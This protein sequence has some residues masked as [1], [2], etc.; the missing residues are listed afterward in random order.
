MMLTDYRVRQREHLLRITRA[1]TA[2]LDLDALLRMILQAATEMLAGQAG[3]VA[4]RVDEGAESRY[5]AR[6]SIGIPANRVPLFAPLL[7]DVTVGDLEQLK[8][9]MRTIGPAVGLRQVVALP[10]VVQPRAVGVIYVFRAYGAGF[11]AD[12]EQVLQSFA[13]QAAI[14]VH[15]AQ[16]YQQLAQEKHRLD[17]LIEATADGILIMDSGHRIVR[18]NHAMGRLAGW[19]PAAT[20]GRLHDEVI[21]FAR[22]PSSTTLDDAEAHGWPL[23][24][25]QDAL[26]GS[27]ALYV[28]AD[29]RRPDGSTVSVGLNYS[30]LL[31][32]DGR[33]INLIA[34]ARDLTRYREAEDLKST[35]ISIISH[36]LKTPVALIKGYAGT[37][38][39]EDARWDGVTLRDSLA[40]IE[41]ESDHLNELINNLLDASRL[42][43]GAL[44]LEIGDVALPRLAEAIVAK[45]RTQTDRHQLVVDFPKDFPL[46]PGDETRLRQVLANL[47]SN[48]I[49]YSPQGGTIHVTGQVRDHDVMVSVH[50]EGIGL[51]PEQRSRVFQ[52]F[53][54]VDDRAT[55]KTAGTGLGLFLAQAIVEAHGGRIWVESAPGGKGSVFSFSLPRS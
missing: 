20:T 10:L 31:D 27:H 45:F 18:C 39:R 48:A 2:Q 55:R 33:L 36:E 9:H 5:A 29:L 38:R 4:L 46:V 8:R 12:D 49:K 44:K 15:N 16:L 42:Q 51:D 37:L 40:V 25:L 13:D 17:A 41:E 21:V 7:G 6:A 43:A 11:S 47:L 26:P 35:F 1:I 30:P 3:L 32:Q 28:E 50:D 52:A 23:A 22:R 54:R 24:P 14:A 34:T 19:D 53:Y